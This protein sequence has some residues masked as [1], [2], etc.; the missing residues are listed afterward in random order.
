MTQDALA[1]ID[2]L[3]ARLAAI[4][5]PADAA[6]LTRDF[7][8]L[9]T[10]AGERA[11]ANKWLL[12]YAKAARRAGE[13]LAALERGGR[14]RP[15]RK[16]AHGERIFSEY[17]RAITKCQIAEATAKR[18]QGLPR[19]KSDVWDDWCK[20]VEEGDSDAALSA[21]LRPSASPDTRI[22]K[23][24]PDGTF[25]VL[26]ADPPWRY[27]FSRSGSR[28]IENQYYTLEVDEICALEDEDGRRV[29]DLGAPD[30]VLFLWATAPKLTE[31]LDVVKSWDFE[32]RTHLVW[33]KVRM[34]MGYYGRSRHELLLIATRGEPGVPESSDRPESIIAV[35][36]GEHS[37]KPEVFYELIERMF[38]GPYVEVFARAQRSG[39]EWWGT[40]AD[41]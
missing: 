17:Q 8:A 9:R 32:Y 16:S 18:W 3:D 10:A 27:E 4:T 37:A 6:Q 28:E 35:E 30:S 34:G 5:D 40:G 7:R 19:I 1:G 14:G 26:Y 41:I 39:W 2:R 33:D 29:K 20:R 24:L 36:R 12:A 21:L 15:A 38:D 11:K 25:R 22:D 13:L 31:S 23:P